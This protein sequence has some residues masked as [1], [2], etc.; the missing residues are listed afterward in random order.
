M[1][2]GTALI[3][4]FDQETAGTRRMLERIPADALNFRPHE[5][6]WTLGQLATHCGQLLSWTRPTLELNELDIANIPPARERTTPESI[7]RHFDEQRADARAALEAASAAVM[8]E[9]WTMRAGEREFFTLPKMV[10]I[11]TFVF[12]HS[13]HHRGQLSV[14]LRLL[15]IPVPGVYGPTADEAM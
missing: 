13:V 12:N 7:L 14:Y 5:K 4:E 15:D 8:A 9:P 11:R 6:S 3:P 1:Q 2:P 10:C